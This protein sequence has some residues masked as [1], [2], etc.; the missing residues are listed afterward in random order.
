MLAYI[1]GSDDKNA[2]LHFRQQIIC[3]IFML[4]C[5]LQV[6]TCNNTKKKNEK[7]KI[8]YGRAVINGNKIV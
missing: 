3:F 5:V 2:A 8:K 1:V 4:G 6:L 7:K